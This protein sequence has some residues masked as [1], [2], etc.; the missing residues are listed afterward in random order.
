[1]R[2]AYTGVLALGFV[3]A[4]LVH[5]AQGQEATGPAAV[6]PLPYKA[7]E[8]PALPTSAAGFS[9]PWNFIQVSSVAVTTRGTVLVLHRGAHPILEFDRDGKL[10]RSWSTPVFSEGKVA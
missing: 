4:T 7:V 10:I 8:W 1:M 6:A 2:M 5:Q 9:A 3:A